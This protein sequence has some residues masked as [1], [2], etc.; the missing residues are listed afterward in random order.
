MLNRETEI[1]PLDEEDRNFLMTIYRKRRRLLLTVYAILIPFIIL[2]SRRIDHRGDNGKIDTWEELE[3]KGDA[4][5]VSGFGMWMINVAFLGGMVVIPGIYLL[6]KRVLPLKRDADSGVKEKIAYT[7]TR[8]QYFPLTEQYFV[9]IDDPE[10]LDREVG[11]D[12]YYNCSPGDT[13]Y[14]YRAIQSKFVFERNGR[15]DLI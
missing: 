10:N 13:I 11:E 15:Y 4:K 9:W 1:V 3:R 5:Y 7:I 2:R 14:I 6:L 12:M 8:K